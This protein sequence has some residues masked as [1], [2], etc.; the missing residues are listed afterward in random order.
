M[1]MQRFQSGLLGLVLLLG[2]SQSSFGFDARILGFCNSQLGKPVG[3]GECAHLAT[4][5]LRYSGAEFLRSGMADKPS[6]GDYVWGTLV[7]S[8]SRSANGT[9]TDTHPA[10]KCLPGDIIQLRPGTGAKMNHTAI[11]ASVNAAGYPTAVFQ[12]NFNGKR[13]VTR[14]AIDL[15][16]DL[17]SRGGYLSIYRAR[18]PVNTGRT[19]FTLVNNA[20]AGPVSYKIFGST[21]TLGGKNTASGYTNRWGTG[22][23]SIVVGNQTYPI[24]PRK[25]YEFYKSGNEI[26]LRALAM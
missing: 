11:V 7:K 23:V 8:M 21:Q 25:G 19:E 14:D 15:H 6:A 2:L 4:E 12:Q 20:Q 26:R 10:G 18:P 16:N 5:A 24:S 3:S 1:L 22:N 13:F 17:K 9:V